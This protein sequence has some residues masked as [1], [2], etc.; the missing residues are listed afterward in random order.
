MCAKSS[1]PSSTAPPPPSPS[2]LRKDNVR[3]QLF[4]A[5]QQ[6]PGAPCKSWGEKRARRN[7]PTTLGPARRSNTGAPKTYKNTWIRNSNSQNKKCLRP[8]SRKLVG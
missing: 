6:L 4:I 3:E 2:A 5:N 1:Y 8:R 7:P